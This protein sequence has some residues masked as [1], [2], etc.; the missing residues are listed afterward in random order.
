MVIVDTM[1]AS[2]HRSGGCS[3]GGICWAGTGTSDDVRVKQIEGDSN[4]VLIA[5]RYI[6]ARK[7]RFSIISYSVDF[8][9]MRK[10]LSVAL[11]RKKHN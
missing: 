10:I 8:E 5:K 9:W 3:V 4:T 11:S 1:A 7:E 6:G 2:A